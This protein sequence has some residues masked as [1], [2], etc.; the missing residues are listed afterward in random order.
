M[1][2]YLDALVE[3]VESDTYRI[4]DPEKTATV[5]EHF[6]GMKDITIVDQM[7]DYVDITKKE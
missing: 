3:A 4:D 7:P 5:V 6:L 2:F 1:V